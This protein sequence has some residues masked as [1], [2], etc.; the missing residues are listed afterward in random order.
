MRARIPFWSWAA[1]ALLLPLAPA[2]LHAQTATTTAT[3]TPAAAAAAAVP[4][5]ASALAATIRPP[6]AT[7]RPHRLESHG[8]VRNDEYYWLNE[9]DNPEVIAYLKA[10]NDYLQQVMKP[11]EALQKTLFDEIV[12]RIPQEDVS[13][14]YRDRGYWYYSR[15]AAGREYP[16]LCRK[17]E[18]LTAPEE[19]ML[20]ENELA[21]GHS[22]FALRGMRVSWS[23]RYAVF[24]VDTVGRR[25]YTL[26]F[27]DLETGRLLPD[28]LE[29]TTGN[30]VWANDDRTV[31]YTRQDPETL[32]WDRIFRHVLGSDAQRD[33]M[34]YREADE[35]YSIDVHQTKSRRYLVIHSEQTLAT[36]DRVLDADHPDGPWRLVEPRRRGHEYALDHIGDRF[37]VRTNDGATNFRLMSAP[38]A[39]PDRAHWQEVVPNRAD[40]F[41]ESFELLEG[42]VVLVERQDGLQHLRVL[43][44]DGSAPWQIDFA[45][46]AYAADL[47]VNVDAESSVVRYSYESLITPG[48]IYDYDLRTRQKTLLKQDKVAGYDP[49]LYRSERLWAPSRDGARVPVSLVWRV[50]R[51][52]PEGNQLLLWG[53]G[54]YGSSLDVSFDSARLSLLD[55]GFVIALAH[56][57]GGQ[58]LGRAWYEHGKLLQK[59]NTFTDFIDVA[60]HLVRLGWT[61]PDKL[62][63]RGGSAGGLLMG[64]VFTMRPD[65][66]KGIVAQV[67]FVDVVTT[68]LDSSIP[69]TAAEWDEWGNPD[70][71][72]YYDYMLSYS[73]YDNVEA[74]VYPNLLVT[75]GLVDSQVQYW[76]PAKWVAR[77]RAKKQGDNLLLLHTN[78][79][80]GHS[81]VSGRFRRYHETALWQAFLLDLAS[82]R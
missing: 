52:R 15:E 17:K 1:T 31:F 16:I 29:N 20:D 50:D 56:V 69:L 30:V 54:S 35:T 4:T 9:R 13:P 73:P 63:A 28:T 74:K 25:F 81:G 26:R 14:P 72:V 71:P 39:T 37:Y 80:A 3:A 33:E 45:E 53:Y 61:S 27:K 70:D 40:V 67:P 32:R 82:A 59:K 64:A 36:E 5:A 22:Y 75:T 10:E 62:F 24:G 46:P 19:V 18:S 79:E 57:R 42:Y 41:L 60:E 78:M 11:T 47:E 65:L 76:E 43:P 2:T 21:A 68:M 34:V 23:G 49:G 38:E 58:E 66:F 48:S 44:A 55:R 12:A 6:V 51:K 77:L 7:P 8:K